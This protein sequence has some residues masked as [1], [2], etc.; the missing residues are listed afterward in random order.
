M[1]QRLEPVKPTATETILKT[2][3][4]ATFFVVIFVVVLKNEHAVALYDMAA[5]QLGIGRMQFAILL[6]I[7]T[8]ISFIF[9]K[10]LVIYL[11][12]QN[13]AVQRELI[14]DIERVALMR[15]FEATGNSYLSFTYLSYH[16]QSLFTVLVYCLPYL[17]SFLSSYNAQLWSVRFIRCN[18]FS[19][20]PSLPCL[21]FPVL[22]F[23][24]SL[25]CIFICHSAYFRCFIVVTVSSAASA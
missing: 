16:F 5:Y 9:W 23:L 13:E 1:A 19:V 20:C 18:T 7:L 21:P 22:P 14:G 2:F 8:G 12:N 10:L 15:L 4:Y 17:S 3:P 24:P 6:M 11:D 25:P